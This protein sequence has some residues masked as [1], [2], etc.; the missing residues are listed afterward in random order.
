VVAVD[1][2]Q[3]ATRSLPRT[4][5]L[6]GTLTAHRESGVAADVMGK[7]AATFVERGSRVAQGAPLARLD[8][9]QAALMAAEA[10]SQ[11]AAARTQSAQAQIE[12]ARAAKLYAGGA[13]NEA[14]RDRLN[15]QCQAT[16]FAAAAAE[17]RKQLAS[18]TLGDL[19]VRAPFAGVVADRFVSAGEYVRPDSKVATVVQLDPLRLELSVPEHALGKLGVG[20][21][22]RFRV[23]AFPGEAFAGR[24]RFVGAQVRRATRDLL[25]EAVVPNPGERLRPGMFAVADVELG[26]VDL[27]V[28]PKGALR[29]DERAG[30][31]RVFVVEAG[32]VQE[33]LVHVGQAAGDAVAILGGL[34]AGERIVLAPTPAL[35]D[36]ARVQ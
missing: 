30:T 33:R 27:P 10:T 5:T 28:V 36:G 22:V 13:I 4:V 3:V 31:D 6:T 16:A 20:A 34:R 19:V 18:K 12:C 14:E 29:S 26:A 2:A 11:A 9:R 8:R 21:E 23:A 32:R 25:V 1:T 24:V 7:V 15:T 35:R 17:A